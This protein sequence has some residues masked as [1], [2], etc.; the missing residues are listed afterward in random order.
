MSNFLDYIDWR[1]DLDFNSSPFNEVDAAILC[2]ITYL[3]FEDLIPSSFTKD[4]IILKDLAQ[5]LSD[6]PDSQKR[7][8]TGALIN[9]GTA[10]LF[11]KAARSK[12]FE[13]VSA[14]GFINK[15][16]PLNEEQFAASSFFLGK[17]TEPSS[18][19]VFRGTDDTIIGWKEDFNL[20]YMESVPAQHDALTYLEN[21]AAFFHGPLSVA[22]HSKGGNLALYSSANVPEKIQKRIIS[23]YNNDG[24]GFKEYFFKTER[25]LRIREK[26]ISCFPSLSII[27]M[28]FTHDSNYFA[29]E[30]DAKGLYQ[31]DLFSWHVKGNAFV[32]EEGTTE[33]SKFIASTV[34][35][36]IEALPV[37]QRENFIETIFSILNSTQAKTNS[38]LSRNAFE[39]ATSMIKTYTS[40]PNE[41]RTAVSKTLHL[42][43]ENALSNIEEVGLNKA[44][45]LKK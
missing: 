35:G 34:N 12:R 32:K 1:G 40:L 2:Q 39:S 24:P 45:G 19:I 11:Y 43:F 31:H 23:I 37:E 13:N 9:Q 42:L 36:W 25:Y 7:C 14:S 26:V 28:L 44:L 6:A 8:D 18:C 29:I 22:G 21:A 20:G 27:G 30:S 16:D 15:I 4:G 5:K 17:K 41:T 33:Q 38:Q 3:D 10:E